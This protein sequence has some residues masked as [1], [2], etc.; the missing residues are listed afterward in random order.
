MNEKII[1]Y[2]M[3]ALI[4]WTFLVLLQIPFQRFKA[5]GKRQ[6]VRDDFKFGES[7]NVPSH[8]IVPNRNYMNLLEAPVLFYVACLTLYVTKTADTGF[9]F[10]AWAYVALRILHSLVHLTYNHVMHRLAFFA[11]GNVVL[12]IIWIKLGFDLV[13]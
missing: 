3:I 13:K 6:V 7:A 4:A 1:F 2:P 9:L 10:L 5:A 12:A 8:V 11:A